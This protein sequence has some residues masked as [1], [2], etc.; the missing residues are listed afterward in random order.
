MW[1]ERWRALAARI[2][3]LLSAATFLVDAL[4]VHTSDV[5]QT[6]RKSLLPEF[7]EISDEISELR[8]TYE[9]ELPVKA[10]DA[11]KR[12][13]SHDWY[14]KVKNPGGSDTGHAIQVLAPLGA[15]RSE[16]EY[17]ISD[18]E[19]E[20]RNTTELAFEHL[21][22]QIVVDD[23]IRTKW[24]NAFSKHETVCERLGAVHLLGHGIWGF[25]AESKG[26]TD[27]VFGNPIGRHMPRSRRIARALVLTEWKLVKKPN[28]SDEIAKQARSQVRNYA[29]GVLGD[30][31]LKRT[32]YVVLVTKKDLLPPKDVDDGV[33]T[34]RHI[35]I[36]TDPEFPSV[37]ARRRK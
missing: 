35:V 26:A 7:K 15:F 32:R 36:P 21:R 11:L 1:L 37:D 5:H 9:A 10:V 16:F 23:E 19:I 29:A 28:D 13:E 24:K 22:R 14:G 12:Y 33:I 34:Y 3:G 2:D 25:K 20:A 4:K 30:L 8:K 6:Y 17:L 27:L 31:E 18:T